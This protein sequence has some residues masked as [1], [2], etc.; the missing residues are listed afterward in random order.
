MTQ[1]L[2]CV[3]VHGIS[4]N[5]GA[6]QSQIVDFV[7]WLLF[8][9]STSHKPSHIL[10]HGFQRSASTSHAQVAAAEPTSSIPG[11]I[12]R[13]PN[14]HVRALKAPVWCRLQALLGSGGDK[15]IMDMLLE[16]AMFRPVE[17]GTANY[18][19]LSGNPIS[20]VRPDKKRK[21]GAKHGDLTE[22]AKIAPINASCGKRS[23]GAITFVRSR[24]L[25]AKAALNAKGGVRFGM[26]H[27][28]EYLD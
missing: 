27:I 12:E 7:V 15:V 13:T 19:Q 4:S 9:R 21:D 23:P 5:V 1:S 22:V 10:C 24:M 2:F 11:L 18:Y 17:G 14:S 20:D 3:S 26:R 6:K 8:R 16:C 25:Y 28:R